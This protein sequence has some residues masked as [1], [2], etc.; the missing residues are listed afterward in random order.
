MFTDGPSLHVDLWA[1]EGLT[2]IYVYLYLC[3]HVSISI[4]IYID[5]Y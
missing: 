5:I 3:M 4:S 1:V 2:P